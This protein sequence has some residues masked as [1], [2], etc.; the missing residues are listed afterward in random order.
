MKIFGIL[1]AEICAA[2]EAGLAFDI[3]LGEHQ[4]S[5]SDR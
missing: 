1:S 2:G 3:I 4:A 5:E